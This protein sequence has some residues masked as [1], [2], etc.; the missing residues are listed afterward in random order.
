MRVASVAAQPAPLTGSS[1][2]ARS[3]ITMPVYTNACRARLAANFESHDAPGVVDRQA[4]A[5]IA[6]PSVEKP[7]VA[8]PL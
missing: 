7:N 5:E 8:A 3:S 2:I 1:Q 4:C 6:P